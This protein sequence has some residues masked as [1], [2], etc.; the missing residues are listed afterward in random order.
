MWYELVKNKNK[1]Y[2]FDQEYKIRKFI[3]KFIHNWFQFEKHFL[4]T[5][6][7]IS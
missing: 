3:D 5:I 2:V 1:I 7:Y 6:Y 4:Y